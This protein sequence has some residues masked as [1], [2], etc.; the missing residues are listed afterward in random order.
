MAIP[1]YVQSVTTYPGRTEWSNTADYV[2]GDRV[3]F[4]DSISTHSVYV[5]IQDHSISGG[6]TPQQPDAP[7]NY[8]R[9][10]GSKEYPFMSGNDGE[11]AKADYSASELSLRR[12]NGFNPQWDPARILSISDGSTRAHVILMDGDFNLSTGEFY[13]FLDTDFFAENFQESWVI[14]NNYDDPSTTIEQCPSFNNLKIG[15]HNNAVSFNSHIILNNCLVSDSSPYSTRT[16]LKNTFRFQHGKF[17]RAKDCLFDFSMC[18]NNNFMQQPSISPTYGQ[19]FLKNTT[20]IFGG[21]DVQY[22]GIFY[23]ASNLIVDKCIFYVKGLVELPVP[24]IAGASEPYMSS[25]CVFGESFADIDYFVTGNSG[26]VDDSNFLNVDPQ[27]IDSENRDYRL[28]PSSPLIGGAGSKDKR[29]EIESQYPEGKWFDSSA[30]DGGDGSWDTPYNNYGEAINSFTGDE[31]VVLIKEGQ[32]PLLAGSPDSSGSFSQSNDLPKVYSNGIKFIGMGS[33]SVFDT[34]SN[35]IKNYGAFWSS[36]TQ[37]PNSRDT[38]FLFKD[39]DILLNNTGYINRGMICCRRAEYVNVNVTQA[40]N[41]GAINSQLFDYTTSSGSGD[42]VEYLKLSSCTINVSISNTSTNTSFLVGQ[43]EGLKQF[44]NC[45]FVDLNRTTS[46]L[47]S[48]S[49]YAFIHQNFGSYAGSYI[50][51]CI[52]YSK[53]PNTINFGTNSTQGSAQG[54]TN[55]EVKNC[56]VF[57]TQGSVSIG[58]NYG[59]GIKELDPKF[60]ATEP[61]DFDLRL[62]ADSPAIGGIS[63]SLYGPD[64]IWVQPG[65]GTGTGTENDA[66]YWSQYS[67]AFLAAVQSTSKQVVFKDGT[68]VWTNSIIQDDNVGNNITMVAENMHQA[69]FTDNGFRLNSSGKTPTLRFKGIQLVANDHFTWQPQCHYILDHIHLLVGKYISAL[70]VTASGCIFEVKS[71]IN[72]YIWNEPGS[73]DIKNC[74]FVDHNDRQPTQSYLTGGGSG[75]IKSSIFYVKYPRANCLRPNT[76]TLEKCASENITNPENGVLFTENLQFVDI[77]NKNYDLRPLSPLIGQG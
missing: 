71:G 5:C 27:F 32:H 1:V 34:S 47:D 56:A 54:S 12:S 74:I 45:T 36:G 8:W 62:R 52:F 61:H 76:G 69:I 7:S 50:K 43:G 68:Y 15:L 48:G 14:F 59:S 9:P 10:A 29:S 64:V 33:G 26:R 65:S 11:L 37:H 41:L 17:T 58:S 19:S 60:V 40:P 66:F 39:F 22:S 53:N 20:V 28:R 77:E 23:Q 30:A 44:S 49:P 57:S 2:V 31:A 16:S 35:G 3:Y 4:S 63:E 42:S 46:V 70:S 72:S 24:K 51:D 18:R 13:S 75:T 25:S 21:Q 67:D 6:G 73:V 55:L 38:P